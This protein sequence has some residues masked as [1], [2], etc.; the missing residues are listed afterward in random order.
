MKRKLAVA[1]RSSVPA[2]LGAKG[3]LTDVRVVLIP[4]L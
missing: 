3:L 1:K 2:K 4:L